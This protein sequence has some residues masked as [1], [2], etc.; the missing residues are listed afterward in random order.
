[1]S[2][3]RNLTTTSISIPQSLLERAKIQAALSFRTFSQHV[4]YLLEQDLLRKEV[5]A[6]LNKAADQP[7][8]SPE[9][10]KA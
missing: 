5:G 10:Q 9:R 1:M 6:M 4:S 7:T 2:T 3:D 8:G